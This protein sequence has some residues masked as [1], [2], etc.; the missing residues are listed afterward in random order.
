MP[1]LDPAGNKLRIC[2]RAE[3]RT[4]AAGYPVP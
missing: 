4:Q 1:V 3:Q 2:T